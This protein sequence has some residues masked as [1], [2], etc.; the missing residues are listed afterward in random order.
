MTNK[1][2]VAVTAQAR[3]SLIEIAVNSAAG[4]H[5]LGGFELVEDHDGDPNGYEARCRKCNQTAWVDFSGMMYSLLADACPG[6]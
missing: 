2:Y 4:N 3:E 1:H 6:G 5:D